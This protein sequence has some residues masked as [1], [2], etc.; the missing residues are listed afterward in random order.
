ETA[1]Y[2]YDAFAS[3]AGSF[4]EV[5]GRLRDHLYYA[6]RHWDLIIASIRR[7]TWPESG[8][9]MLTR[10]TAAYAHAAAGNMPGGNFEAAGRAPLAA[11]APA[12]GNMP[13]GNFE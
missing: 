4:F 11:P 3:G 8:G 2:N 9:R 5:E 7:E 12:P 13:G 10:L 1:A 6:G